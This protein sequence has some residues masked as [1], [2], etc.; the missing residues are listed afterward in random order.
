MFI[1]EA[2]ER[3]PFPALLHFCWCLCCDY[4]HNALAGT[5]QDFNSLPTTAS[6]QNEAGLTGQ[7]YSGTTPWSCELTAAKISVQFL[8]YSTRKKNDVET[9]EDTL[10]CKIMMFLDYFLEKN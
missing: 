6:H 3:V 2:E 4:C 9:G 5:F 8:G 1:W 10:R 7:F